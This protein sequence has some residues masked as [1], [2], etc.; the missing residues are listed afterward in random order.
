MMKVLRRSLLQDRTYIRARDESVD[1]NTLCLHN[2]EPFFI[3]IALHASDLVIA[4][5]NLWR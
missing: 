4:L 1:S 5:S 3:E 2:D